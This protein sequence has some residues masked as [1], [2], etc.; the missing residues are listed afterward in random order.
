MSEGKI[1]PVDRLEAVIERAREALAVE[2]ER[3]RQLA[4]DLEAARRE[5]AR[6]RAE[7]GLRVEALAEGLE[8]LLAEDDS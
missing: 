6:E 7:I 1:D 3:A 2:R 8:E 5:A 4:A